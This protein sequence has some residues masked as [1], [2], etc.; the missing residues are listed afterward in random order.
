M[1]GDNPVYGEVRQRQHSIVWT[2]DL[3]N[4]WQD[5]PVPCV[6]ILGPIEDLFACLNRRHQVELNLG[7]RH[8]DSEMA[9]LRHDGTRADRFVF[10]RMRPVRTLA[11]HHAGRR[12]SHM[13]PERV[14]LFLRDVLEERFELLFHLPHSTNRE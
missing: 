6:R 11:V 13:D 1:E 10:E 14:R 5:P 12:L 8:L 4:A 3:R 7:F 2:N 9:I